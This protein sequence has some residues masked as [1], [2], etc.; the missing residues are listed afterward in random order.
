MNSGMTMHIK[1]RHKSSKQSP[2]SYAGLTNQ[3]PVLAQP[4]PKLH[5]SISPSHYHYTL[6]PKNHDPQALS[7]LLS[8]PSIP[9]AHSR[10]HL[11]R[12]LLPTSLPLLWRCTVRTTTFR[13]IQVPE[14]PA[15]TAMLS[16]RNEEE[17][18]GIHGWLWCVSAAQSG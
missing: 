6:H 18:S 14:A 9:R 12:L 11:P 3:H 7:A 16:V 15:T 8:R 4:R 1:V 2:M 5:T 10:P 13:S 17:S